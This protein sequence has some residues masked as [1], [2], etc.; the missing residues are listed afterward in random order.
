MV[1][2]APLEGNA[3]AVA[4]S[5]AEDFGG[6]AAGDGDFNATGAADDGGG[7]RR[8]PISARHAANN[9][10]RNFEAGQRGEVGGDDVSNQV[11]IPVD[12]NHPAVDGSR[13]GRR[14]ES[15]KGDYLVDRW[16]KRIDPAAAS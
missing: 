1:P 13:R 11:S 8:G 7:T 10:A 12:G 3:D 15:G 16:P 9:R 6:A 5:R 14:P 4:G 2:D